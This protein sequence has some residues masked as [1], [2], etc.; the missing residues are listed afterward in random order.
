[1]ARYVDELDLFQALH[2]A[3]M[4]T[5]DEVPE[6]FFSMDMFKIQQPF[7]DWPEND[8]WN[9]TEEDKER[10]EHLLAQKNDDEPIDFVFS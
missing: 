9:Y 2:M 1:M 10:I 6:V 4:E 8:V 7:N 3:Q 5:P